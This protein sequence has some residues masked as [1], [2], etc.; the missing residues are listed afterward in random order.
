MNINN[1]K[2][3]SRLILVIGSIVILVFTVLGIFLYQQQRN[4]LSNDIDVRMTEQVDDLSNLI[5]LQLDLNQDNVNTSLKMADEIFAK[6]GEL[7][8]LENKISKTAVNQV[9]KDSKTVQLQEW[10]LGDLYLHQNHELVDKIQ[11]ITSST[12]T[13]FQK[14]EGGYLRISTN[15]RLTDGERA[16]GT[17]I[18]DNSP[19]IK[20]I[21]SGQ[22][23][24]GRAWVVDDYYLTA[25]KPIRYE[26][27]IVGIIY[28][29]VKEKDLGYLKSLFAKKKYLETGYPFLV[30]EEGD[31]VI[32]PEKEGENVKEE[33]FFQQLL[34]A[35]GHSG[36]TTYQ[37]QGRKKYQY[38]QYI[39]RIESYVSAS[40]YED[41]YLGIL[42]KSRN[43]IIFGAI[44]SFVLVVL[45]LVI[46]SRSISRGLQRGV[47]FAG[48]ISEGD[49]T[50]TLDIN[51]K[52]EIGMLADA[53]NRM[54]TKLREVVN[55]VNEGADQIS[56]ASEQFSSSSLQ[57]SEGATE[58]ASSIEE[59][60]S[61]MEEMA[62]NIQQNNDHAQETVQVIEQAA[63]DIDKGKDAVQQTVISMKNIADKISIIEE[64]ARQTNL[65]ALNAAVEAARA[66]VHGRGFAVV[67]SEVRNLAERSQE[68]AAE[69]NQ[70]STSSVHTAEN[71]ENLLTNIVPVIKRSA[72]LIR[73]IS[74]AS[75]EQS[76]GVEQINNAIQQLNAVAQSNA[77]TSEEMSNS[78]QE[79][80]Q[81]S[82]EL[83]SLVEF[84]RIGNEAR[85]KVSAV[86]SNSEALN[87]QDDENWQLHT[88][89][90]E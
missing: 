21:E 16:V 82:E 31:F 9:S 39:D 33:E 69:I 52:D 27:Q 46:I 26:G 8:I 41:E 29:G 79:L 62:G 5:N 65:L 48:K 28:V 85:H 3:G 90:S 20:T 14:I 11:S 22:T 43:T 1:M 34:A 71:S 47:N 53:L 6:T 42:N 36:K 54:V 70:V 87:L 73:E 78:S 7:E 81:Q 18:P 35:N 86:T 68:A 23:F 55:E 76:T 40:I 19:V 80:L 83:K 59:V 49:L 57:L 44:F 74:S 64:I 15:V 88:E 56:T 60:S 12:A 63:T 38:F 72:D 4:Q 67:A 30:D 17:Y 75:V 89:Q 45:V 51:Q 25:Y 58:Q 32:H 61:S 50:V 13:I 66:G 37:W 2:I 77:S 84:F 24:K 10:K